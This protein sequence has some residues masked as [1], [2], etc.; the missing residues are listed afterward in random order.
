MARFLL[1][2]PH[3]KD[4]C[5]QALDSV[6]AHSDSLLGRFDWGCKVGEHVGWVVVEA[7]DERTAL[8]L[9]P[10]AIR[11]DATAIQLNKF[12]AEDVKSFH[13]Q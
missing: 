8:M 7:Q 13:Q 1:N 4:D 10:T 3:T 9:L 12:T 5:V 11:D 2:A 6:V